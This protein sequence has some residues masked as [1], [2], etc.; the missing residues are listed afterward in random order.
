MFNKAF[1]AGRR[2]HVRVL[3]VWGVRCVFAALI[4][5][6]SLATLAQVPPAVAGVGWE[7]KDTLTWSAAT[8]ADS[9]RLYKGAPADLPNLDNL[10]DDMCRKG[11]YWLTETGPVQEEDPAPGEFFW[12]LVSGVGAGGEGPFADSTLGNRL[13]NSTGVCCGEIAFAEDFDGPDGDPWPAPW[14]TTAA[15]D[16][17]ELLMNASRLR[18]VLTSYSLARMVAPGDL[19]NG[20]VTFRVRFEDINTQ[21]VG[22]YLRSNGG[23]LNQT[24]PAG[25]GY[26]VFIEGFRGD[27]I[28]LWREI[29]GWE[30]AMNINFNP[31]FNFQDDTWY[32][33]R[34]R[35]L[36]L[37]D[38]STQT[39][40]RWWLDGETEPDSWHVEFIDTTTELQSLSHGFAIDSW[41]HY[42]T[43]G[44]VPEHT[45]VDDVRIRRIC[46]P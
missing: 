6:I 44:P 43:G 22:F 11:D 8:D 26:A 21:G 28:G 1:Y 27:G 15:V 14:S 7:G 16:V 37:D 13:P 18:P 33:I 29:G 3:S 40:A 20:E 5:A 42:Q 23:Y 39:Q 35:V 17:A 2:R 4:G 24:F 10:N 25:S 12:F 41:S 45:L 46:L 31:D 36:Q 19:M 38:F 9:Y 30:Q 32:Q 34:F